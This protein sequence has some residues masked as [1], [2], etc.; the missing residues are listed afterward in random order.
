MTVSD[1][2][3]DCQRLNTIRS[4]FVAKGTSLHAWCRQNRVDTTN[5]RRAIMGTWSG[6]KAKVHV[7]T[8]SEAAGVSVK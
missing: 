8:I 1:N 2:K 4:G 3:G 6:P 7:A 5:A